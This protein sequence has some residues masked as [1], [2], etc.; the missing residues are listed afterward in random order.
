MAIANL[1]RATLFSIT[2]FFAPPVNA[3][4]ETCVGLENDIAR[5]QC[6]DEAFRVNRSPQ[7]LSPIEAFLAFQ[8]L[9]SFDERERHLSVIAYKNP[10]QIEILN[11]SFSPAYNG[12][13]TGTLNRFN[14]DVSKIERV[15]QWYP[16]GPRVYF[17]RGAEAWGVRLKGAV[18][19]TISVQEMEKYNLQVDSRYQGREPPALQLIVK[20]YKPDTPKIASAFEVYV[21]ACRR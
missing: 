6:F 2:S 8:G 19:D 11:M 1:A 12:R 7:Q 3:Q 15:G 10:C 21:E 16:E 4:G 14:I 17:E 20:E 18:P 13:R 5:L 9:V